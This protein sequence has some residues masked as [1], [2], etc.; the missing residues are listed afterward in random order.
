[1]LAD[2]YGLVLTGGQSSRMGRDKAELIYS[3]VPQWRA[4]ANVLELFCAKT[5]WSCTAKQKSAWN[6]GAQALLDEVPGHGPASGLH[7]AFSNFPSVAW[8]VVGC[9]YPGLESADLELLLLAREPKVDAISFVNSG[10]GGPE[11]LIA[12]WEI[13]AQRL[14]L[15]AFAKGETS[16]RRL[17]RSCQLRAI[18]PRED[19]FLTNCNYDALYYPR[20]T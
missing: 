19:S 15:E 17:L 2:V 13:P 14:F 1:M 3:E 5:F 11:P 12:L 10:D 4:I 16:P 18:F 9:D 20:E 6:L 8:L 7:C